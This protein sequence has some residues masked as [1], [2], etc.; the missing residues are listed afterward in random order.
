MKRAQRSEDGPTIYITGEPGSYAVAIGPPAN[1]PS[2]TFE[3]H[4][5]S[6]GFAVGLR[7]TKG[8]PIVDKAEKAA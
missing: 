2:E 3:S 6:Y 8:L 7:M 5:A 1:S 4:K